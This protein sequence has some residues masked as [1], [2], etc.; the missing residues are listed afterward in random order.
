MKTG[1]ILAVVLV[2]PFP[3]RPRSYE[4]LRLRSSKHIAF[5]VHLC[6]SVRDTAPRNNTERLHKYRSRD[7]SVGIVTQVQFP[8]VQDFSF[9]H[10]VIPAPGDRQIFYLLNVQQDLF[11]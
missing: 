1:N 2:L 3:R 6:R 11:P 9:I 7:S 5:G 4:L 10:I 8:L